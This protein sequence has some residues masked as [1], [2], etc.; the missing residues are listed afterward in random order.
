MLAQ[1]AE[2]ALFC[3]R[4]EMTHLAAAAERH[5]RIDAGHFDKPRLFSRH[6]I[7][8]RSEVSI[9]HAPGTRASRALPAPVAFTPV[10]AVASSRLV[11]FA[12][13]DH[14]SPKNLA[15]ASAAWGS[16]LHA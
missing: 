4:L 10:P 9:A 11:R 8:L 1:H 13:F 6:V 3:R 2:V 7:T 16:E 15:A 14:A 5:A 12:P